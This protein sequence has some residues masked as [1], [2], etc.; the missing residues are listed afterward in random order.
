MVGPVGPRPALKF[1]T[2]LLIQG[3]ILGPSQLLLERAEHVGHTADLGSRFVDPAEVS[4]EIEMATDAV[5]PIK[6]GEKGGSIQAA[7]A[8]ATTRA[9]EFSGFERDPSP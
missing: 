2:S 4:V 5:A 1:P 9:G 6:L 7:T 3:Y 8:G